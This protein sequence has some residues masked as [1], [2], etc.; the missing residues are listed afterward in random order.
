MPSTSLRRTCRGR[1]ATRS[2]ASTSMCAPPGSACCA[3]PGGC[4][5]A[6]S[7]AAGCA[8]LVHAT[9]AL[10]AVQGS[11]LA[12]SVLQAAEH[13]HVS[14]PPCQWAPRHGSGSC[15]APAE[16]LPCANRRCCPAPPLEA[17]SGGTLHLLSRH[18]GGVAGHLCPQDLAAQAG[19]GLLTASRCRWCSTS[20]RPMT[21]AATSR[22]R[23]S[24]RMRPRTL[25]RRLGSR[26]PTRL[27][28]TLATRS[29][30][31]PA[32]PRAALPVQLG[33]HACWCCAASSRAGSGRRSAE[34]QGTWRPGRG[35]CPAAEGE[36]AQL[37]RCLPCSWRPGEA[38]SAVPAALAPAGTHT[39]PK[40]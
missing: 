39:A 30:R 17:V 32:A 13:L 12:A 9:A 10:P 5:T 33:R 24:A 23:R 40:A 28:S 25:W 34:E 7:T 27:Q 15:C 26:T 35:C 6:D 22:V 21:C 36:V 20:S 4:C 38:R 19:A 37:A 2:A 29:R 8:F 16:L 1:G 11:C 14:R 18:A 3:L 31:A